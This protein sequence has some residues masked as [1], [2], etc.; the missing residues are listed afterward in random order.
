MTDLDKVADREFATF[1]L[2]TGHGVSRDGARLRREY[3]KDIE[4]IY[5]PLRKENGRGGGG[6]SAKNT[7]RAKYTRN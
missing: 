4:D 5:G 6:D 2:R 3:T 1:L 7:K